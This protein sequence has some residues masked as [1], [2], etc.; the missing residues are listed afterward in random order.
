MFRILRANDHKDYLKWRSIWTCWKGKEIF[1]HPDYLSLFNNWSEIVCAIYTR[2]EQIIMFPFCLREIIQE[3]SRLNYYDVITP[4]GYGDIYFIGNGEF[5][6][7]LKE[8]QHDF[9]QW[10]LDSNVVCEFIRFDLFSKSMS[11]YDGEVVFNNNNVVCEL[12][13]GKSV[14]WKEFNPKVRRNVRKAWSNDL[15]VEIDYKGDR[16]E[17]FLGLYYRTMNRLNAETRYYFSKEYFQ[18]LNDQLKGN[19]AYFFV[20]KGNVE[21]AA[22]LILISDDKI[23]YYLGGSN[24]EYFGLRPNDLLN[25]EIINWGI[26][27]NRKYYVLGG[28]F[29]YNDKLFKYKKYFAPPSVY[30]YK[31]GMK[32]FNLEIYNAL[33]KNIK[34]HIDVSKIENKQNYFFPLYRK[35]NNDGLI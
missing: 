33:T 15:R 34:V 35:G 11:E 1:A 26:D 18:S 13:K 31:V 29:H 19:Y 22:E 16:L 17:S 12:T 5:N 25:Y 32:I 8:F 7:L 20:M 30:P 6:N 2:G 4:Y 24:E 23:Y 10:A 9:H 27:N 28:G 21:I 3:F 14:I